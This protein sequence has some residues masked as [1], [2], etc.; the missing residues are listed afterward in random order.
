MIL[1]SQQLQKWTPTFVAALTEIL[2][3]EPNSILMYFAFASSVSVRAFERYLRDR[4]AESGLEFAGRAVALAMLSRDD[5]LA[6]HR[7]ADVA[8]DTFGFSGGSSTF[9][10]VSV[11]LAVVS[12]EGQ[13]LRSRQSAAILR[14]AGQEANVVQSVES[15]IERT[16]F[17]LQADPG[18]GAPCD[19]IGRREKAVT[20]VDGVFA[21]AAAFLQSLPTRDRS[22]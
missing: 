10:A 22:G 9:D 4:F 13:F 3:R 5:Y 15:F 17:L 16:L 11:N 14:A 8:I 1:V 6:A 12:L 20:A 2:A 18:T 7:C 21:T 19:S